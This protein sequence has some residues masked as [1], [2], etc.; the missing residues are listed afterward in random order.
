M[1]KVLVIGSMNMDYSI[2]TD[3]I[4]KPGETI[5]GFELEFNS[6]GKG[7]NQAYAL[8]KLGSNTSMIGSVGNDYNGEL[9]K[10]NLMGVG[11]DVSG[12][13]TVD[14]CDTGVAFIAV[15]SSGENSIIAV[16]G[17][18]GK[19]SIDDVNDNIDLFNSADIILMQL[20]IPFEVVKYVLE[21]AHAKNKLVVLDPAPAV[22]DIDDSIYSNIDIMK[23]NE[24]ELEILSGMTVKADDDILIAAKKLVDKGVKNVIV[25]LGSKGSLLVNAQGY[26]KYDAISVNAVDTTAA[27][28]SFTAALVRTLANGEGID[29]AIKFGHKVAAL[30]VSKRGAQASIPSLEEVNNY[31][32]E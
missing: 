24:T 10:K 7:A 16:S 11:V 4:P 25:S 8:A 6:G 26:K 3:R 29:E 1:K 23:P 14:D 12:I 27:G 18:N 19:V 20:E 9:L 2:K 28:D 13:K 5:L 32:G 31:Y 15:S 17:A 22:F 21:L 30:V